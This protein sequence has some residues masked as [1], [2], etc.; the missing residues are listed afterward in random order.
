MPS[1][2]PLKAKSTAKNV[3]CV[4]RYEMCFHTS[5]HIQ[6]YKLHAR[7]GNIHQLM[8]ILCVVSTWGLHGDV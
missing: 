3:Y 1:Y 2:V 5:K 7:E 8:D 6:R 4:L